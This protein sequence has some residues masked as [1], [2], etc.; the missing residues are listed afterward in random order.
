ML[1]VSLCGL[2]L[3][4]LGCGEIVVML[5]LAIGGLLSLAIEAGGSDGLQLS[6][7]ETADKP[8]LLVSYS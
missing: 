1:A 3:R 5:T 6:S 2:V 8:Q 7:R 4:F